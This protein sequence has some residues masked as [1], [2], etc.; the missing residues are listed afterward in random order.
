[1]RAL[2]LILFVL[3]L[4]IAG[5]QEGG[6]SVLMPGLRGHYGFIVPHS[7][8]IQDISWSKPWGFEAEFTWLLMGENH[9]RYCFCYPRT[10][11]SFF[12]INFGNPEILGNAYSLYG[13]IEPLIE[14][15]RGSC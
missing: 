14:I 6:N 2:F 5:G 3:R 12:F 15:G 10:G 1:M 11:V 13:F 9:W 4:G 7:S 8:T